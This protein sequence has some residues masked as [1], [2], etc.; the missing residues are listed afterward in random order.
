MEDA[1][2]IYHQN[3][4]RVDP[5]GHKEP[6]GT[7][8]GRP[9]TEHNNLH[10]INLLTD[11]IEGIEQPGQVHHGRPLLIIMPDRDITLFPQPVQDIETFGVLNILQVNPPEA[12]LQQFHKINQ[13]IAIL[14]IDTNR[15][16]INPAQVFK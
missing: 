4:I 14:G 16:G 3:V 6:D 1:L 7:D 13:L 2:A 15:K 8:V 12:G 10:L 9:G 5:G 11:N